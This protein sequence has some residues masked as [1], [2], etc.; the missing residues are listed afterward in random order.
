[1]LV[2]PW[3][4]QNHRKTHPVFRGD[5]IT[6]QSPYLQEVQLWFFPSFVLGIHPDI[7]ALFLQEGTKGTSAVRAT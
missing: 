6:A 4:A 5:I 3:D 7:S 1:M 2:S